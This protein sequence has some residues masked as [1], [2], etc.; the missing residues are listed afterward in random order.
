MPLMHQILSITSRDNPLLKG[1]RQLVRDPAGYRKQGQVWVEGDHLVRAAL[2]RG[3]RPKVVVFSDEKWPSAL[4]LYGFEDIK[5]VVVSELL[6]RELSAL[7]MP[8]TLGCLFDLPPMANVKPDTATVVLDRVQ[9]A[10]NVGSILRCAAAFG[11]GQVLS[12]KGTAALWASK[13]LRAGMG[14]HFGL[15]M[16]EGLSEAALDALNTPLVVTSSHVGE[17]LHHANLPWP[18]AW[19][20]GHEGQG[21]SASLQARAAHHI[22]IAQP[23]GEESLN[24]AAAAAICLYATAAKP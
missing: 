6:M 16:V 14:A 13:T 17:W 9:D 22:R 15:H 24:V 23:G 3:Y 7:E 4:S 8:T 11:Y 10:G 2:V 21:V 19:V 5:L 1:I 20:M 18:C 12:L